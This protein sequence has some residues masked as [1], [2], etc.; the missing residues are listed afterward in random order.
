MSQKTVLITGVSS[1]LG[2]A[3]A[4][5]LLNAGYRVVGT[6]RRAD[7]VREFDSQKPGEALARATASAI[8]EKSL[9]RLRQS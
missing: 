1:G 8:S 7:L 4:I 5:Q 2:R 9:W 6:V 3:F